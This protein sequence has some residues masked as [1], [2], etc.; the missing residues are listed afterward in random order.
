MPSEHVKTPK[1]RAANKPAMKGPSECEGN[2]AD[3]LCA[4]S[5]CDG[6][7]ERQDISSIATTIRSLI[8]HTA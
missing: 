6:S 3:R 8:G 2:Q 1:N 7:S 4:S 5:G